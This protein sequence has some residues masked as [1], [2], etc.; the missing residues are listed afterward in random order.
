[1]I[2]FEL[3]GGP[4]QITDLDRIYCEVYDIAYTCCYRVIN[5]KLTKNDMIVCNKANKKFQEEIKREKDK[6]AMDRI[7][8]QE[9]IDALDELYGGQP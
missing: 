9:A 2:F 6:E 1:M 4:I 5:R 3:I 7:A 8:G